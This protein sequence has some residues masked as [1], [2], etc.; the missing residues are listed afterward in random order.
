MTQAVRSPGSTL[1]PLIYGLAMEEGL[2]LPETLISD[3]PA[4][5][6]GYRPTN[7]DMQYQGDVTLRRALQLSLNVPAIRL[8]DALGP[9]RLAARMR[10]SGVTPLFPPGERPGLSVGLGG[11]GLSLRD[12]VQ[13]YAN[14]AAAP[15]NPISI[16]DGIR[17]HPGRLGGPAM[18]S[19]VAAWHVGD[20]LSGIAPPAGSTDLK[21]AY[22]TGTS[23]GYRDAWAVGYD[24]QHV[25]GV[26]VGRADNGAVPGIT[27]ATTAAPILF[28][29][30]DRSRFQLQPLPKAPGAVRIAQSDLP[31]S[32]KRF[33]ARNSNF[34]SGGRTQ[35]SPLAIAFPPD[36]S[37]IEMAVRSGGQIVPITVKLQGG[38][39]PF[40]I[41]ANGMP[42]KSLNR[43][44]HLQWKPDGA[45]T[46]H[47]AIIDGRGEV[48]SIVVTV[49]R[50]T[51]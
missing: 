30:F 6:G 39:P 1:K 14:L 23:Y 27:G 20:I 13:L 15:K 45:G 47:L 49:S 40:R 25:I 48:R 5:F 43:R 37:D 10:R 46:Q 42:E 19:Q 44:R 41:M 31:G 22:K 16:G 24:G 18:L 17:S 8:L 11:V 2:A 9:A 38:T 50:K 4:D 7:F 33:T 3:R 51:Y 32:L 35:T 29:A 28:E 26:W 34:T 21:I 36:G 12:L